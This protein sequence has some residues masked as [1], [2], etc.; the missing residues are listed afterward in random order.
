MKGLIILLSLLLS[1][2]AHGQVRTDTTK[3]LAPLEFNAADSSITIN[4]AAGVS[5]KLF[6]RLEDLY[7]AA[8][9]KVNLYGE[10]VSIVSF[11]LYYGLEPG[12]YLIFKSTDAKFN[13]EMQAVLKKIKK[14]AILTFGDV[15]VK[16]S[17]DRVRTIEEFSIA[18]Q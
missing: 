13:S 5:M 16:F 11:T 2:Y 3:I 18:V 9:I 15:K 14:G 12:N 8:S 1:G 7:R 4:R 6:I 10:T 17:E